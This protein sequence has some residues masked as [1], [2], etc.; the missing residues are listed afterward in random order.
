MKRILFCCFV[1]GLTL[2]R[3]QA[4]KLDSLD[5]LA[6]K[7]SN[8]VK[9]NL[10]GQ[11]LRLASR[12]LSNDEPDE[13]QIKE[14]VKNLKGIYVRSFEF[15]K[16]GQYAESDLDA[17]RNQLRGSNWN[18]I[19]EVHSKSEG[20]NADI[21]VKGDGDQFTGV[22]IISVEAKELTVVHIDGPIDLDGLSKLSG[23]F[24]IPETV[25]NKV[26]RKSK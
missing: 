7:A 4:L 26:E 19:V 3:G 16:P 24:G 2:A 10:E 25:R 22:A 11:L 9:V 21:F 5:K 1:L 17:I 6:A 12:F 14:L 8:T 23:N 20:D 15:S 13:I 18:A